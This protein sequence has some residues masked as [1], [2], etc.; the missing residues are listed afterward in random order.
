MPS[1]ASAVK[2]NPIEKTECRKAAVRP[3]MR[4]RTDCLSAN[5]ADLRKRRSTNG[6]KPRRWESS[7]LNLGWIACNPDKIIYTIFHYLISCA[8]FLAS[9]FCFYLYNRQETSIEDF[10]N[11]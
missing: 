9:W 8:I 11:W 1:L 3:Q 5:L 4:N 10:G 2:K 7:V 6:S